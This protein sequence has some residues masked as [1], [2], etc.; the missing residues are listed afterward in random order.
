MK[1]SISERRA[2]ERLI[3]DTIINDIR[4]FTGANREDASKATDSII[5]YLESVGYEAIDT[6]AIHEYYDHPQ[7]Y[8]LCK[9]CNEV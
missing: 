4:V 1:V 8:M 9:I 5:N 3:R 2:I 7:P 6:S